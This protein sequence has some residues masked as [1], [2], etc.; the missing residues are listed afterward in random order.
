MSVRVRFAPSPTGFL[1]LGNAR[2][3]LFN[4]VFAKHEGGKFLLRIEDTDPNRSRKEY[5]DDILEGLKWLGLNWDEE[6]VR[7]SERLHIYE[8]YLKELIEN[9]KAY[10]CFCSPEELENERQLQLSQGLIPKYSGKCR[11]IP[12]E[13]AEKRKEKE[14][15]VIRLKMP[16]IEISFNDLIRGK[17]NFNLELIG[18]VIIAK[19]LRSPLY[20]FAVVIDDHEMNITH[21]IRGEDHISN[22]P[23]QLV[24]YE[25]LGFK[26]PL[27]AHL[28]LILGPDKKKL[29][30]RFLDA[31]LNDFK[32]RGY[33]PEALIN[34]LLLLG[35]HP[36]VD[37]EIVSLKEAVED[38]DFKK[39][40]KKGA[41]FNEQKLEWLNAYY[42][43]N[44]SPQYLLEKIKDFIPSSWLKDEEK[45]LK[46]IKIEKERLK[47]L[48][49]FEN[50]ARFAFEEK[51]YDPQLLIWKDTSLAVTIENL[52]FA[53]NVIKGIPNHELWTEENI[54]KYIMSA[55][56]IKGRGELLW[57]LRVA[58]SQEKASPDPAQI[59]YILGKEK[60]LERIEKA[61]QKLN[62]LRE[63]KI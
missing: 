55:A 43:R 39:V 49:E 24:L 5:E 42:I 62:T 46:T 44:S 9:K 47:N 17:I 36:T 27:F 38:F 21:V 53:A 37:K 63:N 10:Y 8:K 54:K 34:F 2:T 3:A 26:P 51:D 23:I 56:E 16:S 61:L 22:T 50:L 6:L 19:N 41:V 31:S 30:K 58:L 4:W 20:N 40:Q 33:L 60:S 59:I 28:P 14:H 1:S 45:L 7:Q 11:N 52:S 13:E 25:Y 29:S 32:K 18:D 48:K 57:P 15:Y 12:L 35:W